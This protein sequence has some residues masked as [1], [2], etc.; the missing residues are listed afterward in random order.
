MRTPL[1][2]LP[3]TMCRL[4]G[5]PYP[6]HSSTLLNIPL[7]QQHQRM[8]QKWGTLGDDLNLNSVEQ[9]YTRKGFPVTGAWLGD[10]LENMPEDKSE[11]AQ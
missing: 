8:Y 11:L 10:L 3:A 4:D 9:K 1:K 6:Q 5:C 7:C 2:R